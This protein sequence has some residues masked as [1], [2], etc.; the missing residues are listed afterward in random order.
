MG[1]KRGV[2]KGMVRETLAKRA[3]RD[4]NINELSWQ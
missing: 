2:D 3:W 1:T 4:W